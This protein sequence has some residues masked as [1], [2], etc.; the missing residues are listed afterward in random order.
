MAQDD[1]DLV[2]EQEVAQEELRR[3]REDLLALEARQIEQTEEL[4]AAQARIDEQFDRINAR[5]AEL[6]E[7]YRKELAAQKALTFIGQ[8]PNPS[9]AIQVCPVAGPNSFVDSF[10]WPRVGHTHQ[11]IDLISPAGPRSSPPTRD[12]LAELELLG[13]APGLRLRVGRLHVLRPPVRVQ[14]GDRERR[15]R[16][17]DRLRRQHGQRGIHEP[18]PLRVPPRRG[19]GDQPLRDA[20]R[21]VLMIR[22]VAGRDTMP[23]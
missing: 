16:D 12:G 22:H 15:R 8:T 6:T 1:V 4:S 3:E 2:L 23:S 10:G 5:V 9:G 19:R 11:G 17:R 21:G 14:L 13:R 18:P 7:K 20:A